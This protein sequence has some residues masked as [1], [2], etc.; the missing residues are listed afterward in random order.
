MVDNERQQSRYATPQAANRC[1]TPPCNPSESRPAS[2]PAATGERNEAALVAKARHGDGSAFEALL[3]PYERRI[4]AI[5]LRITGNPADAADVYQDAVVAAFENIGS[6]RPSAAFGTWLHRIAVNCALMLRRT[7]ARHPMISEGD[8]PQFNWMGRHARPVHDW[9][10][11]P[12][13]SAGRAQLRAAL[14]NALVTLPAIDR[15]IVWMKDVEGLAHEEIAILTHSNV[16]ATRTR[17]H[18]VRLRLRT[19]L[20][21]AIAALVGG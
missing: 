2:D 6:F 10:E 4:Y 13:A 1:V 18:R 21:V 16:L 8:M 19:Q 9:S 14:M 5:V 17:L 3:R 7:A 12:D 15:T 20:G 11:A